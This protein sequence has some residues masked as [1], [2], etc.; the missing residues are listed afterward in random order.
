MTKILPHQ[1]LYVPQTRTLQPIA[2][3]ETTFISQLMI[4]ILYCPPRTLID[5]TILSTH[6]IYQAQ[7][8]LKREFIIPQDHPEELS[9]VAVATRGNT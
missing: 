5:L 6:K 1:A 3:V 4:M 2:G 9:N 7:H 8:N